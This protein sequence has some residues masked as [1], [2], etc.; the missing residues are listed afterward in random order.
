MTVA[1]IG[2]PN[3]AVL[4]AKCQNGA[5]LVFNA[6]GKILLPERVDQQ[7]FKAEAVPQAAAQ[8][9]LQRQ[10]MQLIQHQQMMRSQT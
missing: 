1:L 8:Q 7:I 9:L 6:A 2:P 4:T 5:P 3:D 10:Q